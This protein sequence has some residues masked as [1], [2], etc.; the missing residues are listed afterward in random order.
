[1][2][3][4]AETVSDQ[5]W[6]STLTTRQKSAATVT[7]LELAPA[8]AKAGIVATGIDALFPAEH[9]IHVKPLSVLPHEAR[10]FMQAAYIAGAKECLEF[11]FSA[12]LIGVA[13]CAVTYL[14]RQPLQRLRLCFELRA[15][16][17]RALRDVMRAHQ[18]IQRIGYERTVT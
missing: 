10:A 5:R 3:Y 7:L 18:I 12:L 14:Q 8:A 16:V 11:D 13:I 4:V 1:M 9:R 17:G 6:P 15:F 2:L